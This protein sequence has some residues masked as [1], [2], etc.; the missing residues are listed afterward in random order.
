MSACEKLH[1]GT[2][3]IISQKQ[4]ILYKDRMSHKHKPFVTDAQLSPNKNLEKTPL[5]RDVNDISFKGAFSLYN[6]KKYNLKHN[7]DFLEKF[8]GKAPKE[9]EENFY[10]TDWIDIRDYIKNVDGGKVEVATKNWTRLLMEGVVY[11]VAELPLYIANSIKKALTGKSFASV[12]KTEEQM[13]ARSWLQKKFDILNNSDI[14][15][16]FSGYMETA[17]KLQYDKAE[18]QSASLFTKVMKMF[19]PKSGNYNGVHER[20]LTRIVTGFIPAFF[21]ANDAYN[22]SRIC[23]DDPKAAEKEKKTRFNQETKRVLS[24]AYLQLI[25]LGALSKY[26]NS[27]K[28]VFMLVT[29]LSVIA[30]ESFSRLSNGKKITFI[31]KEQALKLNAQQAEQEKEKANTNKTTDSTKVPAK[32]EQKN[33]TAPN[34]QQLSFKGSKVFQG[35]G[36]AT[37]MP[38]SAMDLSTKNVIPEKRAEIKDQKPL[39]SLAGITKWFVGVVA[40]GFALKYAKKNVKINGAALDK[41]F[42]VVSQKYNKIYDSITT[43]NY[44]I[45]RDKFEE[46]IT[47]LKEYD[48]TFGQ[49]FEDVAIRYQKTAKL[50]KE[51]NN[52]ASM[53]EESGLKELA[54]KFRHIANKGLNKRFRDIEINAKAEEFFNKRSSNIIENN[55]KELLEILKS[56][57]HIKEA[58]DLQNILFKDGKFNMKNYTKAK[59]F[60]EKNKDINK[61]TT[62]FENRFKVDNDGENLKLFDEAVKALKATK[63]EAYA[64][65]LEEMMQSAVNADELTLGKRNKKGV[66]EIADFITQPF[67]FIWGTIT[68][69]YKHVAKPMYNAIKQEYPL[70]QWDKELD[71]VYNGINK[72]IYKPKFR[73]KF[74]N[75]LKI[76]RRSKIELPKDE[77]SEYMNLRFNK[78]LNAATMS[79]ISNSDLSALAKNTSTAATAWFLLADNHNMVMQKSNGEDKQGA[80]QKAKERA[81]Q[82]T[83]RTFYNVLFIN[84]FN[85]TFRNTYNSSL[86][87]A[88]SVNVASTLIGEYVNRKAIGMPVKPSSREEILTQEYENITS[89]GPKGKFFRFMSR[90]TGKKVLSQRD[91]TKK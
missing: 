38:L 28:W 81:I 60:I 67:K 7:L 72:L 69:P 57:R 23:D 43:H 27:K 75:G 46:V 9:L 42:K 20:A 62:T 5:K 58:E 36:L 51:A 44:K 54:D 24:N 22:L 52:I 74:N 59:K 12:G 35:F 34:K 48:A 45:K 13:K 82:E 90:L 8:I 79:S 53:L 37:D 65:K 55:I 78:A 80:I 18:V 76:E 56:D 64:A 73:L 17:N 41:Y 26:I 25:T 30:T 89:K 21:L 68:L 40:A 61:Y 71:A 31:N 14:T 16:S 4:N 6:V 1:K 2:K 32:T 49:K 19:D 87:G 77:F 83:S 29:G 88:Q 85:D 3:M 11:P 39:L 15:N 70:P 86:F 91:N 10:K 47:K 50:N 63:N 66:R 84:L 33:E